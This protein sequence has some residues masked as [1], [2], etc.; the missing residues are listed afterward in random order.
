[1]NKNFID[2]IIDVAVLVTAYMVV[3]CVLALIAVGFAFADGV[4]EPPAP[5]APSSHPNFYQDFDRNPCAYDLGIQPVD[6]VNGQLPGRDCFLVPDFNTPYRLE[7]LPKPVP[8]PEQLAL[9][10][11]GMIALAAKYLCSK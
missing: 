8:E 3:A 5:L 11:L 7:P 4:D 1:M 9:L 10:G 6:C 2:N